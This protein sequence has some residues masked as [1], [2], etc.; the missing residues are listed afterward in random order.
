VRVVVVVVGCGGFQD[1]NR[2]AAA[3]GPLGN[4]EE[5]EE[6]EEEEEPGVVT[7]TGESFLTS[8]CN[9]AA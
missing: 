3:T 8:S 7:A 4:K 9:H 2:P 5:E 6:E 1:I